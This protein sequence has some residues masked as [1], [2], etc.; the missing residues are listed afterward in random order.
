MRALIVYQDCQDC[1]GTGRVARL[2]AHCNGTGEAR[3]GEAACFYCAGWGEIESVCEACALRMRRDTLR[4]RI[5]REEL[6]T[7]DAEEL[8][9]RL[10]AEEA[11]T[12]PG[13]PLVAWPD[14][15]PEGS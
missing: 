8:R 9:E 4:S 5:V 14:D 10:R 12:R 7:P 2:C 1:N 15:L 11:Q 13:R 6:R 3:A